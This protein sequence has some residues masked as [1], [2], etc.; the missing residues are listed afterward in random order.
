MNVSDVHVHNLNEIF[1]FCK[2]LKNMVCPAAFMTFEV[3]L[4][5]L[6]YDARCMLTLRVLVEATIRR[7]LTLFLGLIFQR[8]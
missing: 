4:C 5:V 2:Q 3:A 8:R 1:F 6:L 7:T